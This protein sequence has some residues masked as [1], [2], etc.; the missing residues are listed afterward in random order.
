MLRYCKDVALEWYNKTISDGYKSNPHIYTRAVSLRNYLMFELGKGNDVICQ[1]Q[2]QCEN[3]TDD[4]LNWVFL[5]EAHFW[6]KDYEKAVL[7][8]QEAKM[9]FPN[10]WILYIHGGNAYAALKNYEEAF[11]CWDAAGALG[12]DF[13]DEYYCKASCYAD[14][15]EYEKA[16]ATYMEIAGLLRQNG[17]EEE[18]EMAESEAKEILKRANL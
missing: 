12:T 11:K 9:R 14:I 15:G 6:A 1:Q 16:C 10:S 2:Q 7:V 8:F 13:Y 4:P 5:L 18:A 17:F 3:H